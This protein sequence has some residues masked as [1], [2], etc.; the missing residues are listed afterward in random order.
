MLVKLFEHLLFLALSL[1][2]GFFYVFR[3]LALFYH[4]FR[5]H[6]GFFFFDKWLFFNHLLLLHLLNFLIVLDNLLIV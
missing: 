6:E 5:N 3:F 2:V 4:Y 1:L